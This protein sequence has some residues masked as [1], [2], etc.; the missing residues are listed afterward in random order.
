VL[1]QP[2]HHDTALN[3]RKGLYQPQKVQLSELWA[4]PDVFDLGIIMEK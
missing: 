2:R 3:E 4:Y 1:C